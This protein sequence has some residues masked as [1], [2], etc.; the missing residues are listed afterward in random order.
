MIKFLLAFLKILWEIIFDKSSSQ[1]FK[2]QKCPQ[3]NLCCKLLLYRSFYLEQGTPRNHLQ[4]N[5]VGGFSGGP[6]LN[7][8]SVLSLPRE[9]VQS[10]G[11]ELRS[12]MLCGGAPPKKKNPARGCASPY[13]TFS[14]EGRLMPAWQLWQRVR[15]RQ[16]RRTPLGGDWAGSAPPVRL[17]RAN[18]PSS[19]HPVGAVDSGCCFSAWVTQAPRPEQSFLV[20]APTQSGVQVFEGLSTLFWGLPGTLVVKPTFFLK[21]KKITPEI[22]KKKKKV[23]NFF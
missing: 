1:C 2:K 16:W 6:G 23:K 19:R 18:W 15:Q 5:N 10:L 13:P 9:R 22:L 8:L 11:R 3:N 20:P 7:A 12:H 4:P 17:R 21:R 14:R